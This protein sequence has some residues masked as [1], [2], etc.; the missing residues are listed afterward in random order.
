MT[1]T[2]AV[3]AMA[4]VGVA[5]VAVAATESA[6]QNRYNPHERWLF[7]LNLACGIP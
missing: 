5:A 2:A 7:G 4:A 6:L 3:A 1:A